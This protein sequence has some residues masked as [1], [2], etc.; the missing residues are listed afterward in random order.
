M[1]LL[2]K[3]LSQL[4]ITARKS[5]LLAL[6][7]PVLSYLYLPNSAMLPFLFFEIESSLLLY[8]YVYW[9]FFILEHCSLG[10]C[11]VDSLFSIIS[12][13]SLMGGLPQPPYPK[14]LCLF[15]FPLPALS[16]N[17]CVTLTICFLS[18]C[19]FL[20]SLQLP[21]L[22][23]PP[24]E[25]YVICEQFILSSSLLYPQHLT[26][27]QSLFFS[28]CEMKERSRLLKNQQCIQRHK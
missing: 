12:N 2:L 25:E 4:P 20:S 1:S 7:Y 23:I 6:V 15:L 22:F 5:R 3:A 27:S 16:L 18:V 26:Y 24:H 19:L 9:L 8:E 13:L 14:N 11:I 17:I 21:P 10:L 28:I